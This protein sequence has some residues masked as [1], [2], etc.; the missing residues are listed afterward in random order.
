[1]ELRLL[2]VPF[3]H[4][5]EKAR[6]ALDLTGLPYVEE[7]HVPVIHYAHNRRWGA[8]ATIPALITPEGPLNDSSDILLYCHRHGV[9]LYPRAHEAEIRSWEE[10]FDEALGP[11][12]RIWAYAYLLPERDLLPELISTCPRSEQLM[13]RPFFNYFGTLLARKYRIGPQSTRSSLRE[14]DAIWAQTD[15][16]LRDGRPYLVGQAFSA[17][18]LTLSALAGPML[19]PPEYGFSYPPLERLPAAMAAV[20]V[21]RRE[22]PTGR[23]V[24]RMYQHHRQRKALRIRPPAPSAS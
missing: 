20:I 19:L 9:P 21:A 23:H 24:L 6:W 7:G 22:T 14:I 2:T 18:D 1:M 4:Y 8:G 3:S 11:Q 16:L 10:R 17:A 5:C 12:V 13:A 15:R